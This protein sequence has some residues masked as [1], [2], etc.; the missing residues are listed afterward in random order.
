MS[1][2]QLTIDDEMINSEENELFGKN[3]LSVNSDS[4]D[5]GL[6]TLAKIGCSLEEHDIIFKKKHPTNSLWKKPLIRINA[7]SLQL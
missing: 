1:A 4:H 2:H 6:P 5:D 3:D 7:M